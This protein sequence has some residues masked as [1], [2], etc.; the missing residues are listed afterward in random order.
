[1]W[2][3]EC[4][5]FREC[6]SVPAKINHLLQTFFFKPSFKACIRASGDE[7]LS[8]GTR[9]Q[10]DDVKEKLFLFDMNFENEVVIGHCVV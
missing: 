1:M 4:V 5:H 3:T 6:F 7:N 10:F 8:K 2:G 9:Y